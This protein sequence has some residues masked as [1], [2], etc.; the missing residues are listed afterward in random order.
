MS[1]PTK[2]LPDEH[3]PQIGLGTY[4]L[5]NNAAKQSMRAALRAGYKHIDTAEIY[6]NQ[7]AIG[8][9]LNDADT[10]RDDIFITSKVWRD[11]FTH[12]QILTST[13]ETLRELQTDYLDLLLIHWPKE[14]ADYDAMFR[15][16][17]KLVDAGTVKNIG[18]SNFTTEHLKRVIPVARDAGVSIAVNQVEFHPY[19][20]QDD[21][22]AF[23]E[24]NDIQLEAYAPIAKGRVADDTTL[25]DIADNYDKT[26][27]QVALR[28]A[29]QHGV[30]SIPRSSDH[31]HIEE[32]ID[33][34]D[35]ELSERDM[36]RINNLDEGMRL[37]NPPFA[38]F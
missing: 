4:Q 10:S 31:D 16:F 26:P 24:D 1:T 22:L 2:Q 21:L 15:A 11:H 28:W 19:L 14:G 27:V 38:E 33:V 9:A 35:F 6:D 36:Q 23:C 30:V 20:Y 17:K 12:E 7:E 32:N 5:K 8:D 37:Y 3:I 34:F 25:G 29:V 13:D 18:V